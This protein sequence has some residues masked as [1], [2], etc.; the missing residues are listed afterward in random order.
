MRSWDASRREKRVDRAIEIAK[1]C[2]WPLKIAA[3]VDPTDVLYFKNEIAPLME[4]PLI[5][6][7][8]EIPDSREER[9]PR[10]GAGPAVPDRLA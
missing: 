9:L 8:G 4:H 10:T 1:A 6:F 2:G 5:E 3:K 7:I